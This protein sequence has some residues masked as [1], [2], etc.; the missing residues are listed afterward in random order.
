MNAQELL[1]GLREAG[2]RIGLEEDE[3]VVRAPTGAV[4]EELVER[5]REHKQV[6]I[7]FLKDRATWPCET[8]GRFAFPEPDL[9]CYWCGTPQKGGRG[10]EQPII[11]GPRRFD[12]LCRD[13]C[14][15]LKALTA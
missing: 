9:V 4:P 11:S 12:R 8:C 6:L 10:R 15:E 14:F 2:A 13:G 3:L 7:Q 1:R 5:L